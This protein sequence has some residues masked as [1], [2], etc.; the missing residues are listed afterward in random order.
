MG[1]LL[2]PLVL[3]VPGLNDR[4]RSFPQ[5]GFVSHCLSVGTLNV[6]EVGLLLQKKTVFIIN[7]VKDT[8]VY[9]DQIENMTAI[10]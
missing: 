9:A 5:E 6:N 4:R 8:P 3:T 10:F 7:F 2:S 1:T